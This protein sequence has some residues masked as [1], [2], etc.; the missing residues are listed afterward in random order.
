[1]KELEDYTWF[2]AF[3]R[4]FQMQFI[5][6]VVYHFHIYKGLIPHIQNLSS[7][8]NSRH[9]YDLC[10]GTG[11]PVLYIMKH[12]AFEEAVLTDKFPQ[13]VHLPNGTRYDERS[14]DALQVD[15]P[16]KSILTMFN[17]FH[18]FDEVEQFRFLQRLVDHKQAFCLVEILQPTP[19]DVIKIA[20]TT[21]I[22]QLILAPFIRPFSWTRLLFTYLLPINLVTVT[23]DGIVS[24]LKSGSVSYYR[25][26]IQNLVDEH[27]HLE[28]SSLRSSWGSRL[29]VLSGYSKTKYD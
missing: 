28:V 11:D 29:V 3:L 27:F 18:H 1:M 2:P 13:Q 19:W 21:T 8:A 14:I 26:M 20:F 25:A 22:G 6:W 17:A 24:V 16:P 9:I 5:G 15:L 4:T 23:Y 7:L 12:A 10:S